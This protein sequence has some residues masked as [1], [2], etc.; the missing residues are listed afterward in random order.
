MERLKPDGWASG[1]WAA[2]AAYGRTGPTAGKHPG[3]T[4]IELLVVIAII[5]I[6]AAILFPI[7][8]TAKETGRTKACASNLRQIAAGILAYTGDWD[9]FFPYACDIED[10]YDYQQTFGTYLMPKVPSLW[11]TV[12]SYT[13]SDKIWKCPSDKGI[14]MGYGSGEIVK[15]TA[16]GKFRTS[17]SWRTGLVFEMDA[18]PPYF[19]SGSGPA[20]PRMRVGQVRYPRRCLLTCDMYQY[21]PIYYTPGSPNGGWH[22]KK[23]PIFSWNVAFVDGHVANLTAEQFRNPHDH[24]ADPNRVYRGKGIWSRYYVFGRP[25]VP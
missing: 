17:Y 25:Y 22:V 2:D 21:S 18:V 5:A 11:D 10:Y 14:R 20:G 15:P 24:P 6:L 13:K 1:R 8:I 19:R 23:A 3:F 7:F 12:H 16:F 9:D 4:L